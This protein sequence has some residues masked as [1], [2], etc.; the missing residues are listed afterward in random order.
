MQ[1]T[2]DKDKDISVDNIITTYTKKNVTSNEAE[3]ERTSSEN[4]E[5]EGSDEA[6][7]SVK[8]SLPTEPGVYTITY[9]ISDSWGV[10]Q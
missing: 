3:S 5:A 9:N 4:N 7:D 6:T 1:V 8:N 10:N 2:D